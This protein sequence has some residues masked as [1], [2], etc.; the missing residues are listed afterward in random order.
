[1]RLLPVPAT[2]DPPVLTPLTGQSTAVFTDLST[3]LSS[4]RHLAS[5]RPL[6]LYPGHGPIVSDGTG[7]IETYIAHRQQREDQIL[8]VLQQEKKEGARMPGEWG[9]EG[10]IRGWSVEEIVQEIYPD[11]GFILQNAAGR[12]GASQWLSSSIKLSHLVMN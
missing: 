3:Y 2:D 11:V 5:L 6:T 4:L 12:G 1:M 7:A 10:H 9:K 8:Q